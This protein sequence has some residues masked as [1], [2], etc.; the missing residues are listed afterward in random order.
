MTK[1]YVKI[2]D[3]I[4]LGPTSVDSLKCARDSYL[5]TENVPRSL[6]L[7][8]AATH[9]ARPTRNNGFYLPQKMRDGVNSMIAPYA[10]PV[11][12]HHDAHA[13]PIGRI[14]TAKYIDTSNTLIHNGPQDKL[15]RDMNDPRTPFFRMVDLVDQL[16][17]SDLL[18]DPNYPG[19]GYILATIELTN[20][21]AIQKAIDKRFLTV[22]TGASSD[23]AVCSVCK[24]D[25][26]E[27]GFCEHT[28]GHVYD[29]KICLLIAGT[30]IYD[31]LS[32]VNVP[33]DALARI[34]T[35]HNGTVRDS[36]EIKERDFFQNQSSK[37]Y[38][39]S[40]GKQM[41]DQVITDNVPVPVSEIKV[42][43]EVVATPV[44]V[45]PI[46]TPIIIDEVPAV[47]VET[48]VV[49]PELTDEDK[50][51]EAM[52]AF[53]FELSLM[54]TGFED[55]KLTPKQR[56]NMKT[57]TF[58]KPGERKYPVPDCNHASV[59]MAYAKKN[60][61]S[62]A[63]VACI[64]RKAKALGCP[65]DEAELDEIL[66]DDATR[67]NPGVPVVVP[68]V[69]DK[70]P[71][72]CE[73]L[74]KEFDALKDKHLALTNELTD[75]HTE[76]DKTIESHVAEMVQVKTALTDSVVK[77]EI[78]SGKNVVLEDATKELVGLS[79]PELMKRAEGLKDTLQLDSI[80]KKLNDGMANNPQGIV[81]NPT[82]QDPEVNS[83]LSVQDGV[84]GLGNYRDGYETIL[85]KQGQKQA[86]EY[87]RKLKRE[88][89][90]PLGFIPNK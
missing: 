33:A 88:R 71:C 8:I 73:D 50:H 44:V 59:A 89:L 18:H 68:V 42:V 90:V 70:V 28:P 23:K 9:A 85:R 38:L 4:T 75:L 79:L 12:S 48:P 34:I 20:S 41:A 43:P 62:S 27:E 10:K 87:V 63:V 46:E 40:G 32:F 51:Y 25:W 7:D 66:R 57:S 81:E 67:K 69:S 21:D 29:G 5:S 3:T 37:F 58:C 39:G 74:R 82:L 55:A 19:L 76:H 72:N 6:C 52:I 47:V 78:I 16:V 53:G 24:Q 60:N 65:F 83:S 84:D 26:I 49:E 80:L 17:S 14:I 15:I 56:K 31:E 36:I 61:E 54:D 1:S 30:L 13:D 11:L 45:T 35:I 2:Y 64:R 77:L 86:D 22:S